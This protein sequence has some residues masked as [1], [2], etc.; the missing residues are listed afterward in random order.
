MSTRF[1]DDWLHLRERADQEARAA[2]LLPPLTDWLG[3]RR[4][5]VADLG[6]GTGAN[7][8]YL[9]Q[10][11]P[12]PQE[13]TLLDQDRA[14]MAEATPPRS[15]ISVQCYHVDLTR[16]DPLA[17]SGVDLVT[18]SALLD[19]VSRAWLEALARSCLQQRSA[20][21]L[22]LSYDGT[23]RWEPRAR[24]DD[25]V[26][27]LVNSHQRR[28]KGFGP[29][30]GPDSGPTAD[31]VFRAHGFHTWLS[32]SPWRLGPGQ[33]TLQQALLEGW[34]HAAVEQAPHQQRELHAWATR[35]R[36]NI[37]AGKSS[38]HVGHLDLLALPPESR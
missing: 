2:A 14:L 13:W 15:G 36:R 8:R 17:A 11:L 22:A 4:I 24:G 12:A 37:A 25:L 9:A 31:A 6:A 33:A 10:V 34:T 20:V 29:A 23:I 32:P 27:T 5:H 26:N 18:A 30:L 16:G 3:D 35:R 7:L 1:S 19:L 21:L 38:L 28:D